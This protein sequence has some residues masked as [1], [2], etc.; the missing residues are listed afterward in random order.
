M[1]QLPSSEFYIYMIHADITTGTR[2]TT[3][4][5]SIRIQAITMNNIIILSY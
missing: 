1:Q 4:T 3:V 2:R 5:C